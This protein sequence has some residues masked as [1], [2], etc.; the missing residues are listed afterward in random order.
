MQTRRLSDHPDVCRRQPGRLRLAL[1]A[2][3]RASAAN[4]VVNIVFFMTLPVFTPHYTVPITM[5]SQPR[6]AQGV[7]G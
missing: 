7:R 6:T 1:L 4:L 2:L 3:L 5:R